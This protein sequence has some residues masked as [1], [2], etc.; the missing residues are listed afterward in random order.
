MACCQTIYYAPDGR[1]MGDAMDVSAFEATKASAN[2][3]SSPTKVT[4][5]DGRTVAI[6]ETFFFCPQR[7]RQSVIVDGQMLCTK[8]APDRMKS[9]LL[10]APVNY[11]QVLDDLT[12]KGFRV[13]TA[14]YRHFEPST[15][16]S[17]AGM[18]TS[19][20]G[21]QDMN[22]T[23][24]LLEKDL[25]FSGFLVFS[26]PLKEA[27][28]PTIKLLQKAKFKVIMITGDAALTA[29]AVARTL[30]ILDKN[31]DTHWSEKRNG[32][33]TWQSVDT[34]KSNAGDKDLAITSHVSQPVLTGD[35]LSEHGLT[36]IVCRATVFARTSPN[37]KADIVTCF[38]RQGYK[39]SFCGDGAN[40]CAAMR[41][42]DCGV[43]VSTSDSAALAAS[44]ISTKQEDIGC[45][46]KDTA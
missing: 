41:V 24:D 22:K 29:I 18:A 2:T 45:L 12:R 17:I 31:Q 34:A 27:S 28:V 46:I 39:V 40:D 10:D 13:I 32:A 6:T 25:L 37:Q 14:A 33:W 8:G 19:E 44:F 35:F 5:A 9:V 42:S 7:K 16:K 23:R 26:N 15:L 21:H 43:A 11:D 3:K 4:F 38:R 30:G 1:I 36:D 20:A